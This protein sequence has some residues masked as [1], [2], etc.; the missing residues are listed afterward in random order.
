MS[1]HKYK[2]KRY[3]NLLIL[4]II[5]L[6][7]AVC[8]RIW[9]ALDRSIPA[10]DQADYLT[11]T[12]NYWRSL[13]N[14]QWWNQEWWQS[15]WLLSSKI[16][17]LTYIVTAVVQNIFGIGLDQ[18]TL[19][20][21]LFSAIL[22]SSVYGL[23]SVLFS[24][25]VGLWAAALCQ[26]LPALYGFRLEF[27]LDY[28]LT[29]VV[30]LSFFCLTVWRS[31]GTAEAQ[32]TPR[33]R[34]EV[35]LSL[36]WAV[37]FGITLGLALLV[38][39]TALFFLLTP[40]VWVGVGAVLDRR[41]GRLVQLLGSLCLSV[42]VFGPW[43][44]TNWLLIL[45]SGKRATIDSAI[46][47]GQPGLDKL[48]SWFYY[49]NQLPYQ[50][51]VPL[52]IVPV[53]TLLL[54][55]GRSKFAAENAKLKTIAL[56][57]A[58]FQ[59]SP[60]TW[61]V[62]FWVGGYFLSCLNVNKHERYVLPYL[63][64]LAVLLA[65]G[66]TRS[67]SLLGQR[68]RWG[69]I[70]LAVILMLLN[71]FPVGGVVGAWVT[72]ALSPNAQHYPYM[73]AELPHQQVIAQIIQT[74]PYL[75]STLGVLPSTAEINQHNLNYYG[76]LQNFQVYGRQVGI[77]K[78]Y[79][80]QDGR[81]LEWF[82]TKTGKQ[83]PVKESQAVMVN[84]VEQ[85]GNFQLN[86][87]WNLPDESVLKLYHQKTPTVEVKHTSE[88]KPQARIALSQVTVPEKAPPGLSVPVTYEWSGSWDEL[89][90]GLV[91]LTWHNSR[92]PPLMKNL[93]PQP[94]SLQ[95][96]GEADS[97]PLLGERSKSLWIHD[98]GIAM[99]N[100][101]PGGKKPEGTFQVIEKM[102]MLPP[103]DISPGTYTLEAMYLNRLSGE[104]Y[105]I[106]VPKVT[107]QIE[108]QAPAA[109]TP[110]LDLVTQLETLG[111]QLTK[112]TEAVSQVFEEIG[113]INQYDPTQDYLVQA[114]L[115]LEY[116]LQH[117]TPNRDWAYALAL[118]NVLQR[119]V[120]GAIASLKQVIQLDSENPYAYAYLAFVQLYNWQPAAAQKS[121][122]PSL[123]KNPNLPEFRGLSGVAAL[124]QGNFVKAWKDL[125][126]LRGIQ[127]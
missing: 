78:K 47:E 120:D 14:P 23:G 70:G 21:L 93:T 52:L 4:G 2:R 29:A 3:K 117:M 19:V 77:R 43:Y 103:A 84:T 95:G 7:G 108:P 83:G 28:P 72:Q 40:I 60:L 61:L 39:Q 99:G 66:L 107:L 106:K 82:L 90:H 58:K 16:P 124:M 121:L 127:N 96:K 41:W 86:K 6:L 25:S 55:W 79:V 35:S 49:W 42:L 71:L 102:A 18:A 73:K 85:G 38:K 122:E 81:S 5:W 115:T 46:A 97:P 9:F 50:V 22:L 74:E 92:Q 126:A 37:A 125:S 105:S 51:S 44:R 10:W 75:R 110:E 59:N 80:D 116:R 88:Q 32:R 112:G 27:L 89:Q 111:A 48:E 8:D 119:R 114:R 87:S 17:P 45:T 30:S 98:H 118:A 33:K 64:V 34:G 12:L 76:A 36:L 1:N 123:A 57:K 67:R 104:S 54:W 100:L 113:R 62:V 68:I 65:Y 101:H 13:Q 53:V 11:G 63:P 94:P 26:V 20:M 69:T 91:L 15:L 24:E 109:Q 31:F 56:S